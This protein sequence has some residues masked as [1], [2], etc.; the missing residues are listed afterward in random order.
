MRGTGGKETCETERLYAGLTV[1]SHYRLVR[2]T[3]GVFGRCNNRLT[4]G[5]R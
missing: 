2:V 3:V 1:F 4:V 5:M